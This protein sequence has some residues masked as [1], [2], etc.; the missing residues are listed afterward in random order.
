[1]NPQS[2]VRLSTLRCPECAT[3]QPLSQIDYRKS[4]R[5]THCGKGLRVPY[6][7][8][9]NGGVVSLGVSAAVVFLA[10]GR[11]FW[12]V[13]LTALAFFPVAMVLGTLRRYLFPPTLEIDEA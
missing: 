6:T 13:L 1:L 4:F 9:R 11:G 5:C 7:H 12:L 8:N 2:E 10:G 3:L